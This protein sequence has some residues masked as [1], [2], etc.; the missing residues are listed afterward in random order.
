MTEEIERAKKDAQ[1]KLVRFAAGILR[2]VAGSPYE[3]YDVRHR[4]ADFIDAQ[5]ALH[6]LRGDQLTP[7]EEREALELAKIDR[8]LAKDFESLLFDA[9]TYLIMQGALRL[10][11][12]RYWAKS[13]I[14]V[15]DTRES[16]LRKGSRCEEGLRPDKRPDDVA[17]R[18]I[19]RATPAER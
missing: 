2:C 16:S 3:V 15:G 18:F 10:A 17:L 5:K 12:I 14:L 8:D 19:V 4:L 13:R 11:A 6:A 7:N 9:G 1:Q